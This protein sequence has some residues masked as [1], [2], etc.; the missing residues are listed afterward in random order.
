[1]RAAIGDVI[2]SP[3]T[4]AFCSYPLCRVENVIYSALHWGWYDALWHMKVH[5]GDSSGGL[6]KGS[7][8]TA[9]EE[10]R[11]YGSA[12]LGATALC[13]RSLNLSG[14]LQM[15]MF[16]SA[17]FLKISGCLPGLLHGFCTQSHLA[18]CEPATPCICS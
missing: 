2:R 4:Q 18:G 13:G 17:G 8:S 16:L 7:S 11:P 10:A 12:L 9:C 5:T 6:I 1:M 3:Q 14:P 15:G